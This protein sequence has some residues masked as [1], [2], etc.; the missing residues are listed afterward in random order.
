ML[1]E[2]AERILRGSTPGGA[3]TDT[4]VPPN[5]PQHGDYDERVAALHTVPFWKLGEFDEPMV[6][7]RVHVWRWSEVMPELVRSVELVDG[8]AATLQRRALLLRNPGLQGPGFGATHSLVAAYQMLLP[9]ESAPVHCHSFSALRFGATGS[10]ARMVVDGERVPLCPG[11]LVLTPAWC[12][13]GHTHP[14]GDDPTIWFDG[15]DVPFVGS[16]RAGFYRSAP[17]TLDR[18]AVRDSSGT[19]TP[20]PWLTPA[21]GDAGRHSPVRRYPWD[22]AY[23]ALQRLMARTDDGQG[24]LEYRNPDT[25]GAALATIGCSL[26][27]LPPGGRTTAERETS[28]SVCFVARGSGAL[29]TNG[30]RH[31]LTLND[32]V[33]IPSWTWHEL[34][35]G[36][37]E[38]V[39]FRI[40]DRPTQEAFGLHRLERAPS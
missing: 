24:R 20:G 7:E 30:Q 10:A 22:E 29:V 5:R 16:L 9:G 18:A 36:A 33:A 27:G 32:V 25:G 12:W 21:G 26:Q 8:G 1:S 13:H 37:E 39:L 4:L 2:P 28:S 40:S 3:M 17:S 31:Q 38:L 19:S 14:G 35:A 23:P 34:H 6:P 15:L 11:D